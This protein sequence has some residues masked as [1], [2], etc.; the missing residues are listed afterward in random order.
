[1]ASKI[2]VEGDP[3][4][5][6]VQVLLRAAADK[7]EKEIMGEEVTSI[8][9]TFERSFEQEEAELRSGKIHYSVFPHQI[10]VID[11]AKMQLEAAVSVDTPDRAG[12]TIE[13]N[14]WEL[15][16]F[17]K[18]ARVMWVHDYWKLPVA[19]GLSIKKAPP[20]LVSRMEFWNGD[21]EWGDFARD[22]FAMYAHTPPFLAAFSVGFI[23]K[24]WEA[25]YEADAEG[26]K[27]F[28]GY[29]FKRQELLE[30]SAVPIPM[31]PDALTLALKDGQ[32]PKFRDMFL[33]EF[34]A[35][36][37]RRVRVQSADE[38]VFIRDAL[39][40]LWASTRMREIKRH[41]RVNSHGSGN[42]DSTPE[43]HHQHRRARGSGP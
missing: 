37:A 24:E 5:H 6:T 3:I 34:T 39:T 33:N 22:I 27:R 41:L 11:K 7:E 42:P 35:S 10:K 20:L 12:D 29:N 4:E 31:H 26:A 23:P 43:R 32:F 21:S 40:D 13:V 18:N 25:R 17:E 30:Y 1:M 28:M 2:R 15:E 36:A 16:N 38:L 9:F 19:T 8:P 14:G